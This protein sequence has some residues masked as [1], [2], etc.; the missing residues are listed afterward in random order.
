VLTIF[1]SLFFTL[2][3]PQNYGLSQ[4]FQIYKLFAMLLKGLVCCKVITAYLPSIYFFSVW[5]FTSPDIFWRFSAW[6]G[7][8]GRR[9]NSE[10]LRRLN[11]VLVFGI[12]LAIRFHFTDLESGG[13]NVDFIQLCS[14]SICSRTWLLL[15]KRLQVFWPGARLSVLGS[16]IFL[17]PFVYPCLGRCG[18]TFRE[19]VSI[20]NQE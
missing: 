14:A 11:Y 15:R 5:K 18:S 6:L 16:M 7:C 10:R 20:K 12:Q 13:S 8:R 2:D 1:W 17:G 9:K 4:T 19:L 3:V